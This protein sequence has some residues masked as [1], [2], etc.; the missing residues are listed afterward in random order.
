MPSSYEI[1]FA[2]SARK[3]FQALTPIVAARILKK[4][5]RLA[6][7]DRPPGCKKLRGQSSFWRI[8]VGQYRVIYSI[9][10]NRRIVDISYSTQ[11]CGV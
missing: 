7:N 4:V 2:R 11:E 9:D 3:E 6:F 1:V 8:R 10:D 5:E